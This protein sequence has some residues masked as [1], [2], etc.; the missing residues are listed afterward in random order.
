V[1]IR[2]SSLLVGA[3][4]T[5]FFFALSASLVRGLDISCG[6]FSTSAEAHRITWSYLVRDL[7]LLAMAAFVFFT[8]QDRPMFFSTSQKQDRA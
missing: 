8:G 3:L 7:L 4:L 1:G 5:V 6:C 2:G